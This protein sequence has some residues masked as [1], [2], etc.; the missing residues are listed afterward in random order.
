MVAPAPLHFDAY[1]IALEDGKTTR[2]NLNALFDDEIVWL[3]GRDD[4]IVMSF[5]G[6]WALYGIPLDGSAAYRITGTRHD[7]IYAD[8]WPR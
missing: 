2:L 3:A 1:I 7:A 6:T 5:D 4:V 8:L